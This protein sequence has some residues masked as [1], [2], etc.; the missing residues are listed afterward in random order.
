MWLISLILLPSAL[1]LIYFFAVAIKDFFNKKTVSYEMPDS[2]S[3]FS[4]QKPKIGAEVSFAFY[5]E[6]TEY[7]SRHNLSLSDLI[8]NAVRYYMDTFK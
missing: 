3:E 4:R 5:D 8:R 6:M 1:L 7:C 2:R